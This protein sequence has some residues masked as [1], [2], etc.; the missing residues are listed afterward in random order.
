MALCLLSRRLRFLVFRNLL[1]FLQP[2]KAMISLV[3]VSRLLQ[4]SP[5]TPQPTRQKPRFC[6]QPSCLFSPNFEHSIAHVHW[7]LDK[8]INASLFEHP[9]KFSCVQ[10]VFRSAASRVCILRHQIIAR[11]DSLISASQS[12][13]GHG[14]SQFPDIR[15]RHFL[16]FRQLSGIYPRL[17]PA[18]IRTTLFPLLDVPQPALK[19]HAFTQALASNLSVESSSNSFTHNLPECLVCDIQSSGSCPVCGQDFC[20]THLYLCAE[21]GNQY[22]SNCFDDHNSDGHW[23]D[24]DTAA[25]LSR[26][27][28]PGSRHAAARYPRQRH[29]ARKRS[30]MRLRHIASHGFSVNFTAF[31][32]G[33]FCLPIS[34]RPFIR[35]RLFAAMQ[36]VSGG[37]IVTKLRNP[38]LVTT[39]KCAA[40]GC[41][42]VRRETNHWFV[43]SAELR[44]TCRPYVVMAD[45]R[46]ADEPACG[47][48]CAQKLFERYLA[49]QAL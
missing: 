5:S 28:H 4:L 15:L 45:L 7:S 44:F 35:P 39:V 43:T 32:Q 10:L 16:N 13:A 42:N 2:A 33:L 29:A 46:S 24:S 37:L 31:L 49:K 26:T 38:H 36:A 19:S 11:L 9:W 41:T 20:S 12:V 21:C 17:V 27:Q 1:S 48:A 8:P 14:C 40:P 23:T 47:Q 3:F 30:F 6:E 34:A 25:E 18:A 22:C